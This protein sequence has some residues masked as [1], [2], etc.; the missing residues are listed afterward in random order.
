LCLYFADFGNGFVRLGQ[1][2]IVGNSSKT[3]DFDLPA[4]PKKVALNSYK[5]IL[6]R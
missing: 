2:P 5:E 6:E 1:L 4:Q 3:Y